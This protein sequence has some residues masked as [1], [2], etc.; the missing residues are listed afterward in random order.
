MD[1]TPDTRVSI[2]EPDIVQEDEV[3]SLDEIDTS[4]DLVAISPSAKYIVRYSHN[5]KQIVGWNIQD[6]KEGKLDDTVKPY[7]V[8][9][10]INKLCVSDEKIVAIDDG[11]SFKI[12][13]MNNQDRII[14]LDLVL[15]RIL[16]FN[17]NSKGEFIITF[18]KKH[19][20]DYYILFYSVQTKDN[21]WKCQKIY[22]YPTKNAELISISIY[23]KI[24]IRMGN[25]INECNID[26]GR[27]KIIY[28][29]LFGIKTEDIRI[30]SSNEFTF[31]KIN[32]EIIVY[33]DEY[34]IPIA[35]LDSNDGI[36]LYEFMKQHIGLHS[37]LL[38]LFDYKS[39]NKTWISCLNQIT[40]DSLLRTNKTLLDQLTKDNSLIKKDL[41]LLFFQNHLFVIV[42]DSV[43]KIE[44]KL[45]LD[46]NSLSEE[47]KIYEDVE[48]WM[49]YFGSE[50]VEEESIIDHFEYV[51]PFIPNIKVDLTDFFSYLSKQSKSKN[52][53]VKV[54]TRNEIIGLCVY[55]K[56]DDELDWNL[57]AEYFQ[58]IKYEKEDLAI[59]EVEIFENNDIA[60]LTNIGIFIFKLKDDEISLKYFHYI[61]YPKENVIK[62][63]LGISE[64]Y[65]DKKILKGWVSYLNSDK[66]GFL[67]NGSELLKLAIHVH[68]LK[69]ISDIH[70]KCLNYFKQD[71]ENNKNF[72]SI[73]TMSMPLLKKY[74]PEYLTR[75]TLDTNMII[76]S[77]D[78]KVEQ[79]DHIYICPF[80]MN[81]EVINLTRSICHYRADVD[82]VRSR[83]YQLI[84]DNEWG[85]D[86]FPE[87]NENLL[88]IL[89]IQ[90]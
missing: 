10:K 53:K 88:K 74:Y 27:T 6:N 47:L 69:L 9:N 75:Y 28:K 5:D 78:Y 51:N 43:L 30:S 73:F 11:D 41:P 82:E 34:E 17:F 36:R 13:D 86:E 16:S 33:S 38:S 66:M 12:I 90:K 44:I 21:K 70:K 1:N 31:L 39:N 24:W 18:C 3:K 57:V 83:V 2:S 81:I 52:I 71:L 50:K 61:H 58:K 29:N 60:I 23:D 25:H 54:D 56:C 87:M 37:L 26:T 32:D 14:K 22:K 19:T 80:S 63:I 59:N 35:L 84:K 42:N 68:D 49:A 20:E 4:Y 79:M 46:I 55:K 65:D 62:N 72:L 64:S 7:C 77:L 76:D 85:S 8:E 45:D 89:N 67:K 40:K 48:N 15:D